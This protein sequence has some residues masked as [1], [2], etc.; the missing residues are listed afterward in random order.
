MI[1]YLRHMA[2][3]AR[4]VD[5]GSFR[6]AAKEFGL[7]PSRIS[8]TVSDLERHLG[9]TL[10]HRTTRKVALTSE[11]R[12]FYP[13]VV[14]MLHSVETGL[15]ELNALS[16][17]PVGDLRISVPAFL[18]SSH[19]STLIADFIKTYPR[20]SMSV[21]YSDHPV[22]LIQDGIDLNIRVG[23]LD[24]SAMMSRKLGEF[25]RVL[26]AGAGYADTRPVPRHPDD[27]RD[28]HWIRYEQRAEQVEFSSADGRIIKISGTSQLTVD[29][30]DALHH[31]ARQDLGV[32][33][34]P[35]HLA[36]PGVRKGE[37]VELLPDWSLRPLGCFAVWPDKSRRES[38]TL[39]LVRFLADHF[40][41]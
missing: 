32:T 20:I 38:L 33:I 17:D 34:L 31:F 18:A 2:V 19:L 15:N 39:L 41:R 16:I 9:V 13:R 8:Q 3:F 23:W 10:L 29:S 27:L 36:D 35:R 4:V 28:W 12:I 6:A 26:V 11:G 37:F 40:S 1:E 24:D 21:C 7:A 5:E 25:Q 30:V 14:R 22:G